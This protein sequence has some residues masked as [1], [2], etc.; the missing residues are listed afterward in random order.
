MIS[1]LLRIILIGIVL[2][3]AGGMWARPRRR[4]GLT[5]QHVREAEAWREASRGMAPSE[6]P[7]LVSLDMALTDGLDPNSAPPQSAQHLSPNEQKG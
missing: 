1:I 7:L 4:R 6:D 2:F 5:E 3:W